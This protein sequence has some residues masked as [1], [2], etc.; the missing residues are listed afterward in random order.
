MIL[1]VPLMLHR[2][3]MLEDSRSRQI[4]TAL[5]DIAR[6]GA[7]SAPTPTRMSSAT[8]KM[9][10]KA[11]AELYVSSARL[12]NG[13]DFLP[14]AARIKPERTGR[15]VR[16]LQIRAGSVLHTAGLVGLDVTDRSYFHQALLNGQFTLSDYVVLRQRNTANLIGAIP[17]ATI[18]EK[19]EAVVITSIDINWIDR[20]IVESNARLGTNAFLIDGA[21][22]VIAA[23]TGIESWIGSKPPE[24]FRCAWP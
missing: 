23:S 8:L 9:S 1:A 22:T 10:L 12:G 4:R 15:G 3:W 21:G 11:M 17:T 13:C 19:I 2:V 14:A 5:T 6:T 16:R 20:V 18:D 24:G 7:A